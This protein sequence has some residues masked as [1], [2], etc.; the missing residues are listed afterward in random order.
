MDSLLRGFAGA[1]TF[2]RQRTGP[3]LD[4]ATGEKRQ[5]DDN[6][7]S[8]VFRAQGMGQVRL[9]WKSSDLEGARSKLL[10]DT[11]GVVRS[12]LQ[13]QGGSI[14]QAIDV[15][16]VLPEGSRSRR[17]SN[18]AFADTSQD[19]VQMAEEATYIPAANLMQDNVT[20]PQKHEAMLQF[21]AAVTELDITRM[22]TSEK[23][24]FDHLPFETSCLRSLSVLRCHSDD[25]FA[26]GTLEV[27]TKPSLRCLDV[28]GQKLSQSR[29]ESILA[30]PSLE[31]LTLL[32]LRK[33]QLT[34][35]PAAVVAGMPLLTDL[36]VSDNRLAEI[37]SNLLQLCKHL[38]VLN[39]ES[40]KLVVPALDFRDAVLRSL[41]LGLNSIE[42]LPT[43]APL[44]SLVQ[45]SIC[46]LRITKRGAR[47]APMRHFCTVPVTA[48]VVVK[49]SNTWTRLLPWSAEAERQVKPAL[50]LMFR[51]SAS[52]HSLV[53]AFLA[54]LA[55]D[56]KYSD[57]LASD[58]GG[59][60]GTRGLPHVL[61][62]CQAGE[63]VCLDAFVALGRAVRKEEHAQSLL[64]MQVV[65]RLLQL[66]EDPEPV[67]CRYAIEALRCIVSVSDKMASQVLEW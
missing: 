32:N 33:N 15:D 41:L 23:L 28:T 67:T 6:V 5:R 26:H 2:V 22:Q 24:E 34:Q 38:Q 13:S 46:T 3:A 61:A 63:P 12:S 59:G 9:V 50:A 36:D 64:G 52:F 48:E 44:S 65:D 35:L 29:I 27:L 58:V 62:M 21:L 49:G 42:Y 11:S 19:D 25:M 8:A 1:G 31:H 20:D 39:L 14:S 51:S 66:A 57:V 17:E 40:N 56:D 16:A 60:A 10:E 30:P 53:A 55:E 54:L 18:E 47:L 4:T 45:L 7:W 37:P 43:L